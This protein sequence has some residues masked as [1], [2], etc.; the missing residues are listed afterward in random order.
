MMHA[1]HI[2][3]I[4]WFKDDSRESPGISHKPVGNTE[5]Q[6]KYENDRLKMALAQR[7]DSHQTTQSHEQGFI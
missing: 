4:V 2:K 3:L 6:L 1:L 5:A 7:Y